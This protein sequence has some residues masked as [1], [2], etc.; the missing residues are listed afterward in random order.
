MGKRWLYVLATSFTLV[1]F[2]EILF[3]GAPSFTGFV[4]T[5]LFYTPV[6]Y[7]TLAIIARFRVNTLWSLFLAGALYGWLTEGVLVQTTYENLPYS[8]SDTGLSW[9]ALIT[10]WVGW[11]AMRRALL[12]KRPFPTLLL[13]AAVG[14]FWGLWTPFW[15]FLNEPGIAPFT[16]AR[17]VLL[18]GLFTPAL[19]LSYWL[20]NRLTPHPFA[21]PRMELG[22]VAALLGLQF[23]L[24]AVTPL[25]YSVLVND[26]RDIH[27]IHLS[28]NRKV[29]QL[30][31]LHLDK[32]VYLRC[33]SLVTG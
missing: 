16:L 3:W 21:P 24:T 10:V 20:Q 30:R 23:F 26:L 17:M 1:F 6:A 22:L 25:C 29:Q 32:S 4:E 12:A 19:S 31:D 9:H 18:A 27:M 2:S 14:L 33:W 5:W 28:V 8:L 13:S 15:G 11:Y 7:L